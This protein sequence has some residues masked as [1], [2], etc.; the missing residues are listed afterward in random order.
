[1]VF[2]ETLNGTIYPFNYNDFNSLLEI[3]ENHDIGVIK[4]EV[5][6][7]EEPNKNFFKEC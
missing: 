3:I 4:M 6:R 5:S 7:S 2:R 1:M